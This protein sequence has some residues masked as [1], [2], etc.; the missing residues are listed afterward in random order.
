M[1]S[2]IP[3]IL[4]GGSGT[5]LWPSSRAAH[6]KQFLRLTSEF[7]LLQQTVARLDGLENVK[8]PIVVANHEHRFMVAEHLRQIDIDPNQIILEPCARNTAPAIALAALADSVDSESILLVLPADHL[9][10][11]VQGFHSALN[12]AIPFCEQGHLA[13]FGV[14][15]DHPSTQFGYIK[16]GGLLATG[17]FRSAAFCEK[18]DLST[19]KNFI[20]S[21]RYSWNSG[22]FMFQAK[23]YLDELEKVEPDVVSVCSAAMQ[24]AKM[25]LNFV[26]VDEAEFS[27]SPSNSIDY[28]VMEKT[29][30]GVVIPMDVGWSDIGSWSALHGIQEK[31][32]NQNAVKG[33]VILDGV[34]NSLIISEK[35]LI[36]ALDVDNIVLVETDDAILLSSKD[37]VHEIN[38]IVGELKLQERSEANIHRKVYRPWGS[39]DSIEVG[40]N[41]QVKRLTVKPKAKLSLQMHNHRAEHW[42]V[43]KGVATVTNGDN[44][45]DLNVNESTYIPVGAKH[46]LENQGSDDLELIEVQTGAYLGEDDI[47]RF[48][49]HYGRHK[50]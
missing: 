15:P 5:R 12:K 33:D 10:D 50:E 47:V 49:D 2:I 27:K 38:K 1:T 26:R 39:F 18:P 24:D 7:S 45:F 43:V 23:A 48:D 3:V 11:D 46:S 44:E 16:S 4:S 41:F 32:Q 13:T 22:I 9:I 19:A 20:E 34:S 17:V 8:N 25:D 14:M 35:K 42:V 31:D 40:E 37:G 6:P 30:L 29:E 36:A 21:G 28:A